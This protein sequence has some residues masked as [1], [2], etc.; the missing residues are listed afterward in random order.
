V[1]R[2]DPNPAVVGYVLA[3]LQGALALVSPRRS[4]RLSTL[5]TR[6]AFD[7]TDELTPRPWLV[8]ATR[9]TGLGTLVAGVAGVVV[10]LRADADDPTPALGDVLPGGPDD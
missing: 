6:L 10:E 3:I 5:G 9:I 8:R 7:D 4:I 2:P 1:D